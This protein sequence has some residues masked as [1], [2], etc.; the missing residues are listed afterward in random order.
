[1]DKILEEFEKQINPYLKELKLELADLEYVQDGG[2]SYLRVYIE[3]EEK[4][5]DLEDCITLSSKIDSI[6]DELINE[7]FFLEVSTPGLERSLKKEKDFIRFV[8]EKI[9][10]FT[11]SQFDGK[12]SFE[13]IIDKFEDDTIYLKI[14]NEKI[15]EI[16]LVK[17]KKA[18][19]V[20]ELP[21]IKEE[22]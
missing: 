21:E 17:L 7:K 5:T 13:G 19:L 20:Y 15:L 16:P 3:S 18:N 12:K 2:Y 11:K 14:D 4:Q 8:G 10:I 6:A 22:K 1:M 9:K